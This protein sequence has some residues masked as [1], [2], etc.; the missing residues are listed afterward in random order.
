VPI[1]D[2]VETSLLSFR[3]TDGGQTWSKPVLAAQLQ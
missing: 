1:D 2:C 3:S